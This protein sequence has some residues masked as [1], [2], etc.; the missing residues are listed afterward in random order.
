M[1]IA[2]ISTFYLTRRSLVIPKFDNLKCTEDEKSKLIADYKLI[3]E[4]MKGHFGV[5]MKLVSSYR[6]DMIDIIIKNC[7][8]K[9][10]IEFTSYTKGQTVVE[11]SECDGEI[12]TDMNIKKQ[13]LDKYY[14][15]DTKM[16]KLTS[17]DV[18]MYKLI[19]D[20]D[21]YSKMKECCIPSSYNMVSKGYCNMI[22]DM[23]DGKTEY[24]M[25]YN[26]KMSEKFTAEFNLN[27]L[28]KIEII[29]HP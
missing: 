18:E 16:H 11:S 12:L 19:S 1:T 20:K 6:C 4:L 21:V 25:F 17:D 13:Y 8:N 9:K 27:T 26:S 29:G 15:H 5:I 10:S 23:F 24:Y 2:L 28:T 14:V 7:G 22:D 3:T